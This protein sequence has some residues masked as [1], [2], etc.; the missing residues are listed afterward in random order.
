VIQRSRSETPAIAIT[1]KRARRAEL[2]LRQRRCERIEP[3]RQ[4][5][6]LHA[7]EWP[8]RQIDVE[9]IAAFIVHMQRNELKGSTI[10]SALR[11]LSIILA[12]AARKGRIAISPF[13]Q[14]EHGERPRHDD[15]RPNRI[16]NLD[17]MRADRAC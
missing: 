16:L 13:S 17:E 1:P 11:P 14:L 10:S 8:E 12:Q 4:T 5:F 15:Q 9:D 7:A 2:P 6:E 3:S